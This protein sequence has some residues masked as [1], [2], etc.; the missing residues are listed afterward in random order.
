MPGLEV[1]GRQGRGIVVVGSVN[2]LVLWYLAGEIARRELAGAEPL[3]AAP[4]GEQE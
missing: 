1:P 4:A 3:V 2:W